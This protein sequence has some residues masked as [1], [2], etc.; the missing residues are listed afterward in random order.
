MVSSSRPEIDTMLEFGFQMRKSKT[1]TTFSRKVHPGKY[2]DMQWKSLLRRCG[3]VRNNS[4]NNNCI[5]TSS[6]VKETAL[7]ELIEA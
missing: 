5:M 2:L 6:F 7:E 4:W 3:K 1:T